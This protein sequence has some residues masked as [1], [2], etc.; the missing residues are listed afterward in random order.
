MTQSARQP[1]LQAKDSS[2][3]NRSKLLTT[4]HSDRSQSFEEGI[5]KPAI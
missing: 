1:D 4:V 5:P 3:G 2:A